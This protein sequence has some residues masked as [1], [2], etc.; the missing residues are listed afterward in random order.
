M[1]NVTENDNGT[2]TFSKTVKVT[3]IYE[4]EDKV[5]LEFSDGEIAEIDKQVFE[6]VID[7]IKSK[8]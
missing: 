1:W 2:G 7:R 4:Y 6:E 5:Y 8:R 3:D